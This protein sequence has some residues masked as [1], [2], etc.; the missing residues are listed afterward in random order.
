[1]G[2]YSFEMDEIY[3]EL[4]GL[5]KFPASLFVASEEVRLDGIV[6][7]LE[8]GVL[9]YLPPKLKEEDWLD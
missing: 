9:G 2:K 8:L 1:M 6:V 5:R 3:L 4:D 7:G